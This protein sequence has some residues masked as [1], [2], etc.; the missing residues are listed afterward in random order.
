M[1]STP[2]RT[3]YKLD[4][5]IAIL[6]G[7]TWERRTPS[8]SLKSAFDLVEG[9]GSE[10]RGASQKKGS[11]AGQ[12]LLNF[13]SAPLNEC[14][15]DDNI[16][17]SPKKTSHHNR[18]HKAGDP[19]TFASSDTAIAALAALGSFSRRTSRTLTCPR[20]QVRSL[21]MARLRMI[22]DPH[23]TKAALFSMRFMMQMPSFDPPQTA[24]QP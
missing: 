20:P 17:E 4:G 22:K 24:I 3:N 6:I 8:S 19:V 1:R 15:V 18:A 11:N 7:A 2:S 14:F 12:N 16:A 23:I 10:Q 5:A 13:V 9:I 21:M